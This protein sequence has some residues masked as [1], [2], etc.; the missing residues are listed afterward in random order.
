M[1]FQ[2]KKRVRPDPDRTRIHKWKKSP[3]MRNTWRAR[4]ATLN[5]KPSYLVTRSPIARIRGRPSFHSA[6]V[7]PPGLEAFFTISLLLDC[8][9]IL[10]GRAAE[11]GWIRIHFCLLESLTEIYWVGSGIRFFLEGR[12]RIRL[13][14][15][16]IRNPVWAYLSKTVSRE[17][18]EWTQEI[19]RA[20]KR[21]GECLFYAQN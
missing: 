2:E 20:W 8:L 13:I 19:D 6:R 14:S 15:T 3:Q 1:C 4:C 21:G 16:R 9:L 11:P 12:I 10:G 18:K 7:F 17:Q 5:V